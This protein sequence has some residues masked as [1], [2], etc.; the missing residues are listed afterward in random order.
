[1]LIMKYDVEMVNKILN[2]N[3]YHVLAIVVKVCLV[4]FSVWSTAERAKS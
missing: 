4:L 2:E 3:L 1:M